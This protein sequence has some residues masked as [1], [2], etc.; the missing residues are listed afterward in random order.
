MGPSFSSQLLKQAGTLSLA[1]GH[2]VVD[3]ASV[4]LKIKEVV[5]VMFGF[6]YCRYLKCITPIVIQSHFL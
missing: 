6:V 1:P 5:I 3:S 4:L 2:A